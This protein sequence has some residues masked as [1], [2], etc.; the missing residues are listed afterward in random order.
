LQGYDLR[1]STDCQRK[2]LQY[3]RRR[4]FRKRRR[5]GRQPDCALD[6]R[7]LLHHWWRFSFRS[8]CQRDV[9]TKSFVGPAVNIEGC[10]FLLTT[11]DPLSFK[12]SAALFGDVIFQAPRRYLQ[13]QVAK[14]NGT[15]WSYLFTQ[16]LNASSPTGGKLISES[17]STRSRFLTWAFA[18]FS[19]SWKR[20]SVHFR[21]TKYCPDSI[22][23][24]CSTTVTTDDS[25]LVRNLDGDSRRD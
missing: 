9:W 10:C 1:S 17:V 23:S 6:S 20:C 15:T 14:Q 12:Y 18:C 2:Q 3:V 25:L 5:A 19:R 4:S 21:C 24:K 16:N 7:L 22:R 11:D 8:P 13:T